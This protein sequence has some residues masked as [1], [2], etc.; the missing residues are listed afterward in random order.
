GGLGNLVQRLVVL[1]HRIGGGRLRRGDGAAEEPAAAARALPGRID[2][3][4]NRFD[5]RAAAGEICSFVELANRVLERERPWERTARHRDAVLAGLVDACRVAVGEC[6][7]FLPDGAARLLTRLGTG[8][9]VGTPGA[10]FPR[11]PS[12]DR[13]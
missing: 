7:P 6:L 13:P 5:L 8:D 9:A 4:L 2:G 10:V 1:A 3:A 11:L 12:T